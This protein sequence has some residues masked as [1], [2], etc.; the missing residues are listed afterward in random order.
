MLFRFDLKNVLIKINNSRKV[1]IPGNAETFVMQNTFVQ[2]TQGVK[3]TLAN[4]L[5]L[6]GEFVLIYSFLENN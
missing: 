2:S 4:L 1:T 6:T 3:E 5:K